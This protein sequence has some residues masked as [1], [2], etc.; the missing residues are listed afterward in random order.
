ML[1]VA[2]GVAGIGGGNLGVTQSYIAD[3]TDEAH[4]DR[5]Y[6]LFGVVFG[7]GIVLG[8]IA[9]GFL[10]RIGFW[11]PFAAAAAIELL[12]IALTLRFLPATRRERPPRTD[13]LATLRTVVKQR[14]VRLLILRHVLFI[15]AVTYFF[16]IFALYVQR[17]LHF[18]PSETSW[19]LAVAG[20]SGGIAL[21]AVVD[22]LT[23]RF[24]DARVAR[25]GLALEAAAYVG[26]AF[27]HTPVTFVALLVVWAVGASC[28]EP[29]LSALLSERA[30]ED[31]RGATMGLN[32]A[33]SNLALM[34][35]PA[36]GGWI[37]DRS[38]SA[39]GIV[40]AAAVV[41]AFAL[42]WADRDADRDSPTARPN[43]E[44]SC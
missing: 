5:A 33:M 42:G 36:L 9:G 31:S 6:A 23:R 38:L 43:P 30:P 22:P 26:L 2:R 17:A 29:T 12:N 32:D 40:P 21:P 37:V 41:A 10:I 1:F 4:R 19:L 20:I 35:A 11:A 34:T 28:V 39:V 44:R 7:I 24:G 3:V 13:L 25:L 15:F 16:T 8:P 18:G 14:A 27:V